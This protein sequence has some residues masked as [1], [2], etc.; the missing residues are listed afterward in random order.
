MQ[1]QILVLLLAASC[2][3]AGAAEDRWESAIKGFEAAAATA[4]AK[5]IVFYGSSTI[6]LWSTLAED[7]AGLPV[8][9]RGFGGSGTADALRYAARAVIPLQP[10]WV[11]IYSGGND[12]G[13]IEPAEIAGNVGKLIAELKAGC[14]DCRILVLS[15]KLTLKRIKHA[16]LTQEVNRRYAALVAGDPRLAFVDLWT[17]FLAA[18]GSPDPQWLAEDRLHPSPAAYRRIAELVRPVLTQTPP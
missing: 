4:P 1:R 17:P 8:I 7:F 2:L 13:K 18:D 10:K 5:G 14:P 9:N 16:E 12:I 6:T 15:L 3:F 11:V